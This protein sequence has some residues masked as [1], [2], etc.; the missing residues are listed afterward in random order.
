MNTQVDAEWQRIRRTYAGNGDP[1]SLL[2]IGIPRQV[3]STGRKGSSSTQFYDGVCT[4]IEFFE[5]NPSSFSLKLARA[6]SAVK[7]V[8]RQNGMVDLTVLLGIV[9]LTAPIRL[10][11]FDR[12]RWNN[13]QGFTWLRKVSLA[14][15]VPFFPQFPAIIQ[16]APQH[17]AKFE[18][19]RQPCNRTPLAARFLVARVRK[20]NVQKCRF[21]NTSNTR[22]V[23]EI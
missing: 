10:R 21:L 19:R 6:V 14:R 9:R 15:Q 3:P 11:C 17:I 18:V 22:S 13:R 4:S 8:R 23:P 7:T 12:S 2:P 16:L 1:R 20:L 5:S